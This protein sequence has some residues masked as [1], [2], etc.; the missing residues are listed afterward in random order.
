M[1]LKLKERS[2]PNRH[3]IN[4]ILPLVIEVFDSLH[5]QANVFLHYCANAI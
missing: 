1:Q 2:Y 3:P 5:K 4:Q